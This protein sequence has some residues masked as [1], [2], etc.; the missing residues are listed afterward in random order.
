MTFR[1]KELEMPI[2]QKKQDVL[3][4]TWLGLAASLEGDVLDEDLS[5]VSGK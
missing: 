3:K 1:H 5:S 4:G 2:Y